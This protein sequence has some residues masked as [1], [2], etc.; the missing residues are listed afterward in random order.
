MTP[1]LPA[2]LLLRIFDIVLEDTPRHPIP[3]LLANSYF[4]NLCL[5]LLHSVLRFLSIRQLEYFAR[6]CTLLVIRPKVMFIGLAGGTADS[7][8]FKLLR[9]LFVRIAELIRRSGLETD[10]D[11]GNYSEHG[12]LGFRSMQLCLNSL[13]FDE[14][15]EY[16]FKALDL[17]E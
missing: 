9:E 3:L 14:N 1:A 2:E 8:L 5:S 11:H 6:A 10:H 17:T 16:L 4:R 15:S 7:R 13:R 12:R